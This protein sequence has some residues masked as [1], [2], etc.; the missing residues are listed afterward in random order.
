MEHFIHLVESE[1]Q[2]VWPGEKGIAPGFRGFSGIGVSFLTVS[3]VELH[4]VSFDDSSSFTLH[5]SLTE[6]EV[7]FRLPSCRTNV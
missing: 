3:S 2:V 5:A 6:I 7:F 1:V 4:T